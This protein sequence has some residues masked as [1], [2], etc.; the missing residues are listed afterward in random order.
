[1]GPTSYLTDFDEDELLGRGGFGHVV[2]AR[3]KLDGRVYAVKK[4]VMKAKG[5]TSYAKVSSGSAALF[6]SNGTPQPQD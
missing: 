4:V 3:N 1:M 6:F 5:K 2:K